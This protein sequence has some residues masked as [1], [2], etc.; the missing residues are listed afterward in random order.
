[1]DRQQDKTDRVVCPECGGGCGTEGRWCPL[2]EGDGKVTRRVAN[3][4]W[5]RAYDEAPEVPVSDERISEIVEFATTACPRCVG[6]GR[7]YR[8]P[9]DPGTPC[10]VCGGTGKIGP[11]G[12]PA[13]R[14]A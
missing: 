6:R 12:G 5:Q 1:M 7:Y 13:Q 2:C 14:P 11:D 4:F 3:D 10:A 9:G 8:L